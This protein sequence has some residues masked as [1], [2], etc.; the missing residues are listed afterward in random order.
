MLIVVLVCLLVV[1]V[2]AALAIDVAHMHVPR[3]GLRM[4]TDAAARAG[5]AAWGRGESIAG[6]ADAVIETAAQNKVASRSF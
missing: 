4:A 1:F 2:G 6:A 3:A 5:A